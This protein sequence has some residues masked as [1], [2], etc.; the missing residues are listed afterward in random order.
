MCLLAVSGCGPNQYIIQKKLNSLPMGISRDELIQ[1]MGQPEKREVYGQKE[2]LFFLTPSEDPSPTPTLTPVALVGG[3]VVGI[4]ERHYQN[5]VRAD[6]TVKP[7]QRLIAGCRSAN[8]TGPVPMPL[9]EQVATFK[10]PI[11]QT[12]RRAATPRVAQRGSRT[13][14][15]TIFRRCTG[16]ANMCVSGSTRGKDQRGPRAC[17]VRQRQLPGFQATR[18]RSRICDRT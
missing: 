2:F 15:L 14:S 9:R 3:K 5:V 13:S 10:R 17:P 6:L 18:G 7:R 1:T 8:A 11:P 16:K 4:G 12:S